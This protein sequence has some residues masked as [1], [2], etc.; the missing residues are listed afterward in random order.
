VASSIARIPFT[1]LMRPSGWMEL[2]W[3]EPHIFL[4]L[5]ICL[6]I[7]WEPIEVAAKVVTKPYSCPLYP[8]SAL[9]PNLFLRWVM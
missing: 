7:H 3:S 8:I 5:V 1:N 6:S 4:S 2:F 9:F